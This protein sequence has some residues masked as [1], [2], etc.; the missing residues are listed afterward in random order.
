MRQTLQS[1]DELPPDCL[2]G[3]AA[4]TKSMNVSI[5]LANEAHYDVNDLGGSISVWM[6]KVPENSMDTYFVFPNLLVKTSND[7]DAT[8]K[9]GL[10]VKLCDGCAISWDGAMLRHCTSMRIIPEDQYTKS[11]EPD[12]YYSFNVVHNGRNLLEMKRI[13]DAQYQEQMGDDNG[14]KDWN[15]FARRIVDKGVMD[16]W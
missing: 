14:T 10:L 3:I 9:N 16:F 2:G 4:M 5:N 13:R 7:S 6:K 11:S 1:F 12:D 15:D 8:T